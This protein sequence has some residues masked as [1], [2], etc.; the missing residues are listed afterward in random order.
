MV[1]GQQETTSLCSRRGAY[2]LNSSRSLNETK[3]LE[4]ES[5]HRLT[6]LLALTGA[7]INLGIATSALVTQR[8]AREKM[9]INS[10]ATKEILKLLK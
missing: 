6:G 4:L 7:K 8:K 2:L 3:L 5:A 10:S 1:L 9:C